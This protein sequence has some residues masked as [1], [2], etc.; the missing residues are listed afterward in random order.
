MTDCAPYEPNSAGGL[1]STCQT[2][3]RPLDDVSSKRCPQA[4]PGG[5]NEEHCCRLGIEARDQRLAITTERLRVVRAAC[6]KQHIIR[7]NLETTI[8]SLRLAHWA[9]HVASALLIAWLL[10]HLS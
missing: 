1:K 5:G 6:D 2:C 3:F 4:D 7:T 9:T 10:A 8:S